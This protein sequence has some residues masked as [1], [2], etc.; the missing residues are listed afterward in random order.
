MPLSDGIHLPPLVGG[1]SPMSPTNSTSEHSAI[2]PRFGPTVSMPVS[3]VNSASTTPSLSGHSNSIRRKPVPVYEPS[4]PVANGSK[5][6][7][8]PKGVRALAVAQP[9]G[10]QEVLKSPVRVSFDNDL[11]NGSASHSAYV[12]S[13]PI[14]ARSLSSKSS[15]SLP[16]FQKR[17]TPTSPTRQS[18]APSM[19]RLGSQGT[20]EPVNG[21]GHYGGH[22][23][24]R[25]SQ[26]SFAS[27]FSS[28]LSELGQSHTPT[29]SS[30]ARNIAL[31]R[32]LY[33]MNGP[34]G[35]STSTDQLFTIMPNNVPNSRIRQLRAARSQAML[36]SDASGMQAPAMVRIPT[37]K[38]VDR[39]MASLE[40]EAPLRIEVRQNGQNRVPSGGMTGLGIR[41][42]DLTP[43]AVQVET[44]HEPYSTDSTYGNGDTK[45]LD[46]I[47]RHLNR[48]LPSLPL[49]RTQSNLPAAS[50]VPGKNNK[51]KKLA[52]VEEEFSE[53]AV[54]T[55]MRLWEAS[56][57]HLLDEQGKKRRFGDFWDTYSMAGKP[58]NGSDGS[59]GKHHKGGG[60]KRIKAIARSLAGHSH[61]S[62][63][64][65]MDSVRG[66][67][68]GDEKH[69]VRSSSLRKGESTNDGPHIGG[70]EFIVHGR[71]T[72]VFWIRHF[73]CGQCQDYT[74]ASLGLLDA[75]AIHKA[76]LNVIVRLYR[77]MGMTKLSNDFGPAT[78]RAAYHQHSAPRQVVTAIGNGLFKMP[79]ANPGTFTQLGGEFIVGPGL[80]CDFAHRMTN[81]SNHMEAFDILRLAGVESSRSSQVRQGKIAEEEMH[82]LKRLQQEEAEWRDDRATELE[83]IKRRKDA[84]RGMGGGGAIESAQGEEGNGGLGLDTG[85]EEDQDGEEEDEMDPEE[86]KRQFNEYRQRTGLSV[87]EGEDFD[88]FVVRSMKGLSLKRLSTAIEQEEE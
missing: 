17:T 25:E 73:W 29:A 70:E 81:T 11:S 61:R 39:Q 26:T 44:Q 43:E 27:S 78:G 68:N 33:S 13:P 40:I 12:K 41:G 22:E 65:S 3:P 71:K 2:S 18:V 34:E 9:M 69:H 62:P 49:N 52:A 21:T 56:Q 84:R 45:R 50:T 47:S 8:P 55:P 83:R 59:S 24:R 37:D 66:A 80:K 60:G 63:R 53:H 87:D 58:T 4:A 57:C 14:L 48:S 10:E 15:K 16:G 54:P 67:E 31:G 20:A 79:L 64:Q 6:I 19:L 75:E 1:A 38:S 32:S 86:R 72:V 77:L 42:A 36:D 46:D 30:A 88:G 51:S 82:E 74:F 85:L 28:D 35:N 23:M 5:P 76:G 7:R